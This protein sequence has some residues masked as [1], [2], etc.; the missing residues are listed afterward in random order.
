MSNN[1]SEKSLIRKRDEKIKPQRCKNLIVVIENPMDNRNI[2]TIIRNVNVLG[3]DKT[4]IVDQRKALPD[5]WQDMRERRSLSKASVSAIKWSFIKRFDSTEECLKH[6]EKKGFIN[7]VTSPHIKRKNNV[8]LHAKE[9]S[10]L[11]W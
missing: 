4:Y 1:Q 11:V 9:V 5:N 3:V 6:L 7:V 10:S 2:G 8:I